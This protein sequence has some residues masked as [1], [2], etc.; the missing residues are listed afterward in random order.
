MHW[1]LVPPPSQPPPPHPPPPPPPTPTPTPTP[2]PHTRLPSCGC[3]H[4]ARV[5]ACLQQVLQEGA[6]PQHNQAVHAQPLAV[7]GFQH[8]IADFLWKIGKIGRGP[9]ALGRRLFPVLA[10]GRRVSLLLSRRRRHCAAAAD[11][12]DDR[13][14]SWRAANTRS[15]LL[16]SRRITRGRGEL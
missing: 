11:D 8:Q 1:V 5:S 12:D 3:A 13:R 16:A 9:S 10:I 14:R 7:G 4:L 2:T 6:G 15:A